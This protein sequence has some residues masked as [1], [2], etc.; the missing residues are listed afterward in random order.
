MSK[1]STKVTVNLSDDV[2]K[3][4]KEMAQRDDTTMTE[5]LKRAI[6]VHKYLLEQQEAGNKIVV[7]DP[8]AQTQRELVLFGI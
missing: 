1:K 4:L 8:N 3:T 2:V 6:A 5:V 7:D